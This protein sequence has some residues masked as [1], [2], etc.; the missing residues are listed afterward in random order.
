MSW[1]PALAISVTLVFWA[2]AFV[3]IRHLVEEFGPGA[4][5]LGRLAI[6]AL[7]LSVVVLWTRLRSGARLVRPSASQWWRLAAIGVLWYGVYQVALNTA[8]LHIDA[9]T[10]SLVLQLSPVVIAL[11]AA[12]VLGERFT[13]WLGAG[14]A[15]AFAG[16]AL[17]AFS[18]GGSDGGDRPLVGVALCLVSVVAYAV[19]VVLQKPLATS[20][21]AVQLT[22]M[23]CS[24]GALVTLPWAGRL[25]GDLGEASTSSILWLVF[26]GVFP[27]AVAF[28]T[29]GYALQHL[30]AS[31][32][33]ITT[34][35]VPV[36]SIAL[37]ALFLGEAPAPLAYVGGLVA[38][39]GVAVA[40]HR[41]P[42]RIEAGQ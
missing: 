18:S 16:V 41:P 21:P 8:E 13:R 32:L 1:R 5:A 7:A 22:W 42:V 2:S 39:I 29:Y 31:Q 15:L 12:L 6:G 24:I 10:A 19:S 28:T 9:G 3:A 4:L 17:I 25:V 11:L 14:L 20:I 34:Y 40:R 26:L 33:G 36:I 35:A 23:A 38:L 27:T 37:A 30:S